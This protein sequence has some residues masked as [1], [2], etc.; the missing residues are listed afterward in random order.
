MRCWVIILATHHR[1]IDWLNWPDY[2]TANGQHAYSYQNDHPLPS[3]YRKMFCTMPPTNTTITEGSII[4]SFLFSS[5]GRGWHI[6]G[7]RGP[8]FEG[9]L[10]K[11]STGNTQK[12]LCQYKA[13]SPWQRYYTNFISH[14]SS[15]KGSLLDI[16]FETIR[17]VQINC[18]TSI[19]QW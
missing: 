6:T 9:H 19:G 7:H 15:A 17:N 5:F 16:C 13:S 1:V 11:D 10:L 18:Q 14:A 2:W 4:S 12:Y 3:R 8:F